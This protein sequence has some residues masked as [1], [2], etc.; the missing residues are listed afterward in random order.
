[1]SGT[2][3]TTEEVFG[4]GAAP[5]WPLICLASAA[6]GV[7]PKKAGRQAHQYASQ[8]LRLAKND[9]A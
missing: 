9:M 8:V 6:R 7:S 4:A 1:M 3:A 5:I 2:A